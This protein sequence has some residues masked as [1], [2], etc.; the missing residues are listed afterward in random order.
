VDSRFFLFAAPLLSILLQLKH[1]HVYVNAS[2][3]L[4]APQKGQNVPYLPYQNLPKKR[5][6]IKEKFTTL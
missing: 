4:E 1:A 3:L 6:N 2:H 5:M